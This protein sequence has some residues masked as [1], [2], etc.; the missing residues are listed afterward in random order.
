MHYK[1]SGTCSVQIDLEIENGVI[2]HC[3]FIRG[4]RGNTQGLAKMVIGR[5]ADEVKDLLRGI[6]C[7]G[8]TSC[9]D[10]LSRAIEAYQNQ[11]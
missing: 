7:R 1:T 5:K 10:Q 4:C 2:T 8:N 3:E 11:A 6:A 9:P